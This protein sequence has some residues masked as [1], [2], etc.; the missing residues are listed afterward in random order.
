MQVTQGKPALACGG[1][2]AS[3]RARKALWLGW[4]SWSPFVKG[5]YQDLSIPRPALIQ[6]S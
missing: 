2:P 1:G 6:A 3:Q 5:A 4:S